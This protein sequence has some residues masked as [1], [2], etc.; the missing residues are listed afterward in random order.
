MFTAISNNA[1]ASIGQR[2]IEA[3][4]KELSRLGIPIIADDTGK[5][6]G[7]TVYFYAEDGSMHVKSA[8][9]GEWVL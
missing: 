3:V 6:F 8:S 9:K 5:D 7:R 4:R 1:L 2:N